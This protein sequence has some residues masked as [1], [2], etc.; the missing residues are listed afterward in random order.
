MGV[1]CGGVTDPAACPQLVP[2]THP[3]T[4]RA[5]AWVLDGSTASPAAGSDIA[6][7]LR[8]VGTHSLLGHS[9]TPT[10]TEVCGSHVPGPFSRLR[11]PS[12]LS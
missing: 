10:C 5:V 4:Q 11:L 7:T 6:G 9:L 2:T 8:T 3:H 1:I 12:V